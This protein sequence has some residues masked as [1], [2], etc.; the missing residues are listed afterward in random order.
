MRSK[1]VPLLAAAF[2]LG[3]VQA[4]SAADMP[5]KAPMAPVAVPFNWSGFYIG[6]N[7][8]GAFVSSGQI[9]ELAP[10]PEQL[11]YNGTGDL[12]PLGTQGSFLGGLQLGY[13]YQINQFVLG[14]EAD[15]DWLRYNVSAPE[16]TAAGV[17]STGGDTIGS[18]KMD[19]L[20]TIRGRLGYAQDMTV[21]CFT[22]R[23]ASHFRT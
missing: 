10:G 7:A 5:T 9:T 12:M 14:M 19:W 13:N 23:V 6:G 3:A 15:I 21:L 16:Q 20:S 4:A 2:S 11:A 22:S 17:I 8:G 1:I 18:K